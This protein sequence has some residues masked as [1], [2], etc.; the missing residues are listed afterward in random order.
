M[1]IYSD[2]T[3]SRFWAKVDIRGPDECWPWLAARFINKRGEKIYGQFYV[4][5]GRAAVPKRA[6]VMSYELANG[7][8]PDGLHVCH[9]CDN[10][11]CVNP[12][13]LWVG[14]NTQNHADKDRKGRHGYTGTLGSAHPRAKLN[15]ATVRA[16]KEQIG[17][18]PG[19]RSLVGEMRERFGITNA[20]FYNIKSGNCWAHVK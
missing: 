14:T 2:S 15:E 11:P 17:L 19:D 6:H 4:G 3:L 9:T 13:H 10:P 7:D 8:V 20:D 5:P 1:T 12:K 18:R 16:I